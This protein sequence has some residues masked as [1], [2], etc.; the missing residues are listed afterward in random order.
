MRYRPQQWFST[1]PNWQGYDHTRGERW[2]GFEGVHS[3]AGLPPEILLVPL[4]GHTFGHAG[5]AVRRGEDWLLQAG[6]AYFFHAETDPERPRCTPGLRFYQWMME[7]DRGRR[8]ANR[9]RLR[10]LRRAAAQPVE[11]ICGHDPY[12]FERHARAPAIERRVR[13]P[14]S[15]RV[16]PG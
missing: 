15:R 13:P 1:L 2:L 6:D 16:A 10:E 12:E 14:S 7:K 8:L 9:A 3:L 5:V 11:I 4:I